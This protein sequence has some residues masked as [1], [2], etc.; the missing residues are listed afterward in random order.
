MLGAF[1]T[2]FCS[3]HNNPPSQVFPPGLWV[4]SQAQRGSAACPRSHSLQGAELGFKIPPSSQLSRKQA[5]E[6]PTGHKIGSLPRGVWPRGRGARPES[7]LGVSHGGREERVRGRG[8]GRS[9]ENFHLLLGSSVMAWG[10]GPRGGRVSKERRW[11]T[12]CPMCR[13]SVCAQRGHLC[14]LTTPPPV[15]G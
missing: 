6:A 15:S 1:Q 13:S 12:S 3:C 7:R 14:P 11:S 5:C 8:W 2:V 4:N 9:L 10:P